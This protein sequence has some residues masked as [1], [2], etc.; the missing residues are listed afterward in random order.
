MDTKVISILNMKGG[1]GKSTV[2]INLAHTLSSLHNKKVLV[3]DFDP[4]ANASGGLVNYEK[5]ADHRKTKRVIS[6]I[7]TDIRSIVGPIP[8]N[9]KEK[10]LLELEDM[11]CSVKSYETGAFLDLVP[12]ELE[13]SS[14]L[15]RTGGSNIEDRLKLILKNKKNKYDIILVDCSP[16]YSVLTNN[17]LKASDYVLIPVKPDPFSARGIPML[18]N[19]I[20]SHN[21]AN[22][23]EDKVQPLG[24]VFTMVDDSIQYVTSVKAEIIREHR[25]VF[26][27]QILYNEYYSRGIFGNSYILETGAT[28]KFKNNFKNFTVEFLSKLNTAV[29]I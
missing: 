6:D 27:N 19:K 13:L 21:N 1:V 25:N 5:Y 18:L 15:E 20:A 4:Q 3:V 8:P 29:S 7:F 2:T 12:S 11:T 22:S 10:K 9:S 28:A 23:D 26:R 17:A 16:T 24:I 14:V